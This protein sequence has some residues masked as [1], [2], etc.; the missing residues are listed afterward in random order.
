M[1]TG[2]FDINKKFP[3]GYSVWICPERVFQDKLKEYNAELKEIEGE[4]Y[5]EGSGTIVEYEV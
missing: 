5:Y 1:T 2:K 3:V 4:M